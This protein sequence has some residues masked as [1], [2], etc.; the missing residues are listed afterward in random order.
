MRPA[1]NRRSHPG[2]AAG[3]CSCGTW[4][5]PGMISRCACGNSAASSCDIGG[6]V[7]SSC[8]PTT[9]STGTFTLASSGRRSRSASASQAA[10]NTSG[11]VLQERRAAIGHQVRMTFLEFRREQPAHRDI[12]DRGKALGLGC[13]SH[14]AKRLAPRF[15]KR[16]AAIGENE[17]A[18]DAGMADRHLQR[19]EAAIAVAEHDRL[20]AARGVLH[21]LRHPVGD[22]G[23]PAAHG[24]RAA[25]ARQFRNDHARRIS[26]ARARWRRNWRG[27][28]AASETGT[29]AVPRPPARR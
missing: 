6:G 5:Q 1:G 20:F 11:S 24:L 15:R 7:A 18:G 2:T 14:V 8:S 27:P 21:R 25:E 4:A 19:D 13:R 29:A 3:D 22:A 23:K 16:R 9:T 17:P 26:Q 10:R 12:G 28:T